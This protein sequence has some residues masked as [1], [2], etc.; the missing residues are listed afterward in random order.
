MTLSVE[1]HGEHEL[2]VITTYGPITNEVIEHVDHVRNFAESLRQMI[3][4]VDCEN[5]EK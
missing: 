1:R 5:E 3:E 2:R 4:I